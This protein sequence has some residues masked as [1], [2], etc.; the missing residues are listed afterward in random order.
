MSPFDLSMGELVR[1][2]GGERRHKL[3]N[4]R[5]YRVIARLRPSF[6]M[7][8]AQ[9]DLDAVAAALDAQFPGTNEGIRVRVRSL[10]E[11]EAGELRPYLFMVTAAAGFV[12]LIC[13]L[14]VA[15]LLLSRALA[16]RR[17]YAVRRRSGRVA[18]AAAEDRL[19]RGR[20]PGARRRGAG[21]CAGG[22]ERARALLALVPQL[23]ASMRIGIDAPALGFA[24]LASLA[25]TLLAGSATALFAA[26]ADAGHTLRDAARG[27][28]SGGTLRSALVV[29]QVGL[30]LLLLVGAGLLS[31]TFLRLRNQETGFSAERLLLTRT[32]NFRPG[33]RPEKSRALPQFQEQ[34]LE[35]MRALPGV[36]A[37]EAKLRLPLAGADVS[38]GFF[39]AMGIPFLA[40]RDID[41]R[42]STDSPMVVVVVNEPA[43]R[44][45]WP[46][47]D[48]IG[49]ELYWGMDE[50]SAENPYCQVVGVVGNV[51]HL[52]GEA[53]DGLELYYPYTQFPV[54]NVY[55]LIRTRDDP[56]AAAGAV[57]QASH[58]VD[59]NAAIVFAKSMEQ[60][61]DES[62][63]RRRLWS[64]LLN[65]FGLLALLLVALGLVAAFGLKRALASLLFGVDAAHPA[66]LAGATL[67]LGLV[68]LVACYLPAR[69]AAR[70]DPVR[71]LREE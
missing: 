36:A 50:P 22:R 49:Q 24:L 8:R 35:R 42:D 46:G 16:A 34:V 52:A 5:F 48:P 37:E 47:R 7:G 4:H 15:S 26:S 21:H 28:T 12:L 23:P 20:A 40:G 38:P 19:R 61:I 58:S 64:V 11:A 3:R 1:D 60:L 43:A 54:T 18:L 53:D 25:S 29:S 68:A 71:A 45:P 32:T 67:L 41:G 62:L 10:R 55:Y 57:R 30:A 9:A 70:L 56:L 39:E 14:N 51:R 66:S 44:T 6:E 17:D 2:P 59:R 33:T 63:W 65:A 69:R 27:S 31:Q 13:C